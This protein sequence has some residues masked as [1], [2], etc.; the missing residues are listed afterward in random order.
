MIL[1]CLI[2][3]FIL[4]PKR[5]VS[6][7]IVGRS[8]MNERIGFIGLGAM[9]APIS[10]N[11]MNKGYELTVYDIV[12]ERMDSVVKG[13]AYAASSCKEV[14]KRSDVIITMVPGPQEVRAVILGE[15]GVSEGVREG[16]IVIDMSTIDPETTRDVARQLSK[17][18]AKMLDAPVA[19]GVPAAVAGTL[20]IFVGGEK[21]VFEKCRPLLFAMGSDVDYVGEIG[22][23]EIVKIINNLIVTTTMCAL[24]EAFVLG[25]KAGVEPGVLFKALSKGSA[26]SFVLQNH[27]KNCVLKGKFEKDVFPIN[28]SVKDMNL[29]LATGAKFHVPLYFCSLALQTLEATRAAGYSERYLPVVI[30]LLEKQTGVEVRADLGGK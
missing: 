15:G 10:R 11:L 7:V 9:G 29:V 20:M 12:P 19:R 25:V 14:A 6:R 4:D 30:R 17:K 8:K 16:T 2:G 22:A 18:G 3:K 21:S 5:N 28:Y 24:A 13:G 27:V 1:R 26:N 23:G